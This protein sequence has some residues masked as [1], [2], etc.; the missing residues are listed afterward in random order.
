VQRRHVGETGLVV[1]GYFGRL[2]GWTPRESWAAVGVRIRGRNV[3]VLRQLHRG[4]L[5]IALPLGIHHVEFLS[6]GRLV[7]TERVELRDGESVLVS[8]RPPQ[9]RLLGPRS[10]R[11]CVQRLVN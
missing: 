6:G 5:W 2:R 11:W 8:F 4:P 10:E 3:G 9:S 1:Y 7:H